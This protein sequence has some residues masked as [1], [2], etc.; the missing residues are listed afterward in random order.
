MQP[1]TSEPVELVVQPAQSGWRL[2]VFLAH[3]FTDYSRVHLRR[4][5]TAGGVS[6]D[7]RGGKPAYRLIPGQRVKIV[8]P[9][10]PAQA[11]RRRIF[12]SISF[13]KTSTWP[14]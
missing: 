12:P 10:I 9:E 4:V 1:I 13:M 8:L 14:L 7:G 2:D 3:H 6:I 5:I 11:P